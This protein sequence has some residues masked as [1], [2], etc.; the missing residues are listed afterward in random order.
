M[1]T[2]NANK[3]KSAEH[4]LCSPHCSAM[5]SKLASR[6]EHLSETKEAEWGGSMRDCGWW[7]W[8][9]GGGGVVGSSVRCLS[10]LPACHAYGWSL[11]C[12]CVCPSLS[13]C[14]YVSIC[15]I[16]TK[17][18][19]KEGDTFKQA[20]DLYGNAKSCSVDV[21]LCVPES[22]CALCCCVSWWSLYQEPP[23]LSVLGR[24]VTVTSSP[25]CTLPHPSGHR[26]RERVT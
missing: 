14:V 19:L 3:L 7:W 5:W 12:M 15:P 1:T 11:L 24:F 6:G 8:G 25:V 17:A 18:P 9:C 21:L 26:E 22:G 10:G 2:I 23:M 13:V 4:A 20:I 16:D